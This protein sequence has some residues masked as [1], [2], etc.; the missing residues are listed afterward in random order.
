MMTKQLLPQLH[1]AGRAPEA[2]RVEIRWPS[3]AQQVFKNVK[4]NRLVFIHET[5][6]IQGGDSTSH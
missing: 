5:K 2:E 3:G 4:G 6:G 1:L